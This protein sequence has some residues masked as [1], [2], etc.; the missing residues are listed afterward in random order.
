MEPL[1]INTESPAP[2]SRRS[3]LWEVPAHYHCAIIGTCVPVNELRRIAR[4]S[5][6][7]RADTASDYELHHAAVHSVCER[8]AFSVLVHKALETRYA[9]VVRRFAKH[10]TPGEIGAQWRQTLEE[11]E[12][13]GALWAVMSHAAATMDVMDAVSQDMHMLSHQ[14]GASSRAD[15]K[16]LRDLEGEAAELRVL[17]ERQRV[18]FE[19]R[20]KE[21]DLAIGALERRTAETAGRLRAAEARVEEAQRESA[22]P[23]AASAD[24]DRARRAVELAAERA[25]EL[26]EARARCTQLQRELEQTRRARDAALRALAAPDDAACAAPCEHPCDLAGRRVLCVGGRT[27]CVEQYRAL[28]ERSRGGFVH[29]DGGLEHN[30][31][32]LQ[33]LLGAADAVICTAGQVSHG[34]YYVVKRYCKQYGKPCVLLKNASVASFATGLQALA[35]Q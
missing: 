20:L 33:T 24:V 7:E 1:P 14:A 30:A 2:G 10:R 16:R 18:G 35:A 15:L 26:A 3:R 11:G 17:V 19:A 9:A 4:R 22:S 12:A 21:R 31:K 8:N 5:G 28:V 32:R 6:F 27:G 23:A 34:A 25:R 29:H 13:A